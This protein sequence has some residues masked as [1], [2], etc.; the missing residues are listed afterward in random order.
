MHLPDD[1]RVSVVDGLGQ[2]SF[3][4][5]GEACQRWKDGRHFGIE[6]RLLRGEA[7]RSLG[8]TI[9][10]LEFRYGDWTVSYDPPPIPCRKHDWAFSHR[11]FDASWEGEE[12]GWIGNGLCGTA[13]SPEECLREIHWI[14]EDKGMPFTASAE[15]RAMFEA[16]VAAIEHE[17]A[18]NG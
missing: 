12:D 11:D 7:Y 6:G 3:M 14:E 18:I 17:E 15:A 4:T 9:R 16:S 10:L 1:T 5:L 13:E 2:R 8:L